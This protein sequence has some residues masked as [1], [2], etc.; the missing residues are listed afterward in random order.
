MATIA[1]HGKTQVTRIAPHF[2]SIT[3]SEQS[4]CEKLGFEL[5][6]V[7][8]SFYAAVR[9][10]VLSIHLKHAPKADE[11]DHRR[12]NEHLDAYFSVSGIYAPGGASSLL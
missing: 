7:Y 5:D 4:S 9:R 8:G 11:R 1:V 3:W 12:Q 2:S 10:D 6:F